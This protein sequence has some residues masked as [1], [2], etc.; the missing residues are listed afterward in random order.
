MSVEIYESSL[1]ANRNNRELKTLSLF[2][3]A[4]LQGYWRLE[5]A[6][7]SSDNSYDLTN[8]GTVTFSSGKF[9]NAGNFNGT[10][11]ALT[12]ADASSANLEISGSQSW[13][14]WFKPT[15]LGR[16]H[17]I[18]EKRK[19]STTGAYRI[20]SLNA[21]NTF[22]FNISG[23]TYTEAKSSIAPKLN[24]WHHIVGV[25]DGTNI[26][27]YVN[28]TKDEN[29][30]TGTGDDTNA[31]LG[32]GANYMGA[33]DSLANFAKGQIDDCAIFDRA[34]TDAEVQSIYGSGLQAYY[35]L[36][37]DGTDDSPNGYDLT[38]VNTPT[39][40]AGKFGNGAN[41]VSANS[42][43][44]TIANNLGMI[45]GDFSISG[46]C[47][48]ETTGV[49][50]YMFGA[51]TVAAQDQ[52]IA[53]GWNSATQIIFTFY[54]DD[55]TATV[56][57]DTDWHHFVATFDY[58]T[59]ARKLYFDN[60]LANS[61][62]SAGVPASNANSA[63]G[64]SPNAGGSAFFNG[65]IDDVAIFNRALTDAE[66]GFIYNNDSKRDEIDTGVFTLT[67]FDLITSF[68]LTAILGTG[69]FALTGFDLIIKMAMRAILGTGSF[70][71]TGFDLITRF[72][73]W[74]ERTKP[75]TNWSSRTKPTT[76]WTKRTK[77]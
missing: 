6:T 66:V 34:L 26:K 31:P 64:S 27:I 63:I 49:G 19:L 69:T 9:N 29:A 30:A 10:D 45:G 50:G 35:R 71:F 53:L 23:L 68:V 20:I 75:T 52:W 37:A 43:T 12:I 22:N 73:G 28:G 56:T 62:T 61:D 36:E 76:N 65:K 48:K 32:I 14:C 59:K 1:F 40:V 17:Q 5:D 55:L 16:G 25:Y 3:D 72:T 24:A 77:P 67:G 21:D 47:K 13:S 4:N 41:L 15:E 8:N 60:S 11:Q 57:D 42:Q 7:D 18:M 38:E 58:S 54:A 46:W 70:V 44:L 51:G 2:N 74:T 33:A 39:Y